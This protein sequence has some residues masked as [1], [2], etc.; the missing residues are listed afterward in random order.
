MGGF[1]RNTVRLTD[2]SLRYAR[3]EIDPGHDPKFRDL[4]LEVL[5]EAQ[6]EE[7]ED[8]IDREANRRSFEHAATVLRE[9]FRKLEGATTA[10][11]ALAYTLG[12]TD[13]VCLRDLGAKFEFSKQAVGN[14][15]AQ[16]RRKLGRLATDAVHTKSTRP[17]AVDAPPLVTLSQ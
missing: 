14:H 10:G 3:A 17:G 2:T 5:T 6:L 12:T 4:L 11:A 15:V 1:D 9:I 16:I 8:V 13:E 7:V